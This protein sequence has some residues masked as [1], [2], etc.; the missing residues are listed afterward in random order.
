MA[1]QGAVP[2]LA[3]KRAKRDQAL[4]VQKATDALEA[5]KSAKSQRKVI[6]KKAAAYVQEYRS[7]ASGV[8]TSR[9]PRSID[10]AS[11]G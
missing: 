6:F 11:W 7:Q 3:V 10:S 4:A 8:H 1:S 5:K 2:E 9:G